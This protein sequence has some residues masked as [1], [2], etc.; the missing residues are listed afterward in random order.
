MCFDFSPERKAPKRCATLW[1]N[2]TMKEKNR[3][4]ILL[5][6]G[7]LFAFILYKSYHYDN[8][9]EIFIYPILGG[10]GLYLFYK[11]ISGEIENYKKTKELK[12][13]SLTFTG[14]LL[15]LLNLGI[16]IYYETKINSETLIKVENYGVYADFKKNGEYVIKSG[17]WASK[18]HFYGKYLINDSIITLDK[19]EF[20]NVLISNRFVIRNKSADENKN[21]NDLKKYI[22]QIDMNGKEIK[23]LETYDIKPTRLINTS[24]EFDIIEY[25]R[26]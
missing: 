3:I 26:K 2:E 12:Y 15:I 13:Y 18:K 8:L 1:L 14:I 6:V 10:I 11:G 4:Y 9:F 19:N 17:S 5:L 7:I 23:N 16:Y 24:Y 22:V 20:D 21:T 25:N